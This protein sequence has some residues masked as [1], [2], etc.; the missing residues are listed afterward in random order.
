MPVTKKKPAKPA[1]K[2]PAKAA[3]PAVKPAAKS[4][5]KSVRKPSAFDR[6][7]QVSAKLAKIVGAGPM[8]RTKVTQQ[9]WAYIKKK[10]CQNPKNKREII[11]DDALAEVFG[12]SKPIDMFKMTRLVSQ[13]LT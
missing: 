9:I 4:A 5:A 11:P 6:P 10:G 2:A 13:H 7:V 8:P 3:K 12:T 1:A